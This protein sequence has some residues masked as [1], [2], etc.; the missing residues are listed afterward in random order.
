MKG[1][2]LVLAALTAQAFAAPELSMADLQALDKSQ[3]WTEILGSAD[4]VK[5]STRTPDWNRIVTSAATHVVGQI[6]HDSDTGLR[7]AEKLIE[8]IPTAETKYGFLKTDKPYL[9]GKAKVLARVVTICARDGYGCGRFIDALADGIDR[10]PTGVARQIATLMSNDT[11]D[12]AAIHYWAL[13]VD[14]DRDACQDGRL[15]RAVLGTMHGAGGA[16]LVEAQR[17]A[18]TCYAVLEIALV[19]A[20]D[21]AKPSDPFIANACPVLKAHGTKT[22]VKK[23]CP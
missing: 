22:I 9:A 17:A 21:T 14:D 1:S 7:A 19:G 8:L 18:T 12:E 16:R 15:E 6:D 3:S 20:L 10:F 23:K 4:R 11:S 2:V 5:P 13:A